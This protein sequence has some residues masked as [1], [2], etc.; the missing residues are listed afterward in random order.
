MIRNS[1]FVS[2]VIIC[3]MGCEQADRSG[4]SAACVRED[5][6][7]TI[8]SGTF[9]GSVIAFHPHNP[10]RSS[11]SLWLLDKSGDTI[12]FSVMLEE[13]DVPTQNVTEENLKA[14][15]CV[16]LSYRQ[17]IVEEEGIVLDRIY[18]VEELSY[19]E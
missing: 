10:N 6:I 13:T 5:F 16:S 9:T 7:D 19:P 18:Y 1:I 15:N 12:S 14:G 11:R 4:A 8:Q 17:E 2:F 3:G